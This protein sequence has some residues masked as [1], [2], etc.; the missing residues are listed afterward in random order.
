MK[1]A[2]VGSSQSGKTCIIQSIVG[3]EFDP[4]MK[5]LSFFNLSPQLAS[6]FYRKTEK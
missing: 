4:D 6:I 5:V 3:Y 2:F 1:I